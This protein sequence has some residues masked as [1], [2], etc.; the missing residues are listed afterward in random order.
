MLLH[1]R[2]TMPSDLTAEVR[3][4]I[5]GNDRT[6]NIVVQPGASVVPHGDLIECDVAREAGND[7]L[8][9]LAGLGLGERGGIIVTTP[10]DAPFDEARR[11]EELAPGDP[12]DVVIWA[13][14]QNEAEAMSRP[15][16]SYHIFLVLAVILAAIA[17]ITDSSILVVGAMVVGPEFGAIAAVCVGLVFSRRDLVVAGVKLVVF[18]FVF[19][20]AVVTLLGVLAHALGLI[21]NEAVTRPRPQTGFIWHPEPWSFVV[22]LVA[23]MAGVLA[24]S[25]EKA[26][27]MV[28]VLISVTTVPAAGNLA[29]GLAVWEP[30]EITGSLAQLGANISGLILAGT[31][32]LALQRRIWAPLTIHAERW[33]GQGAAR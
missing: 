10:T 7:L 21:T 13:S 11:L 16:V 19:A 12:D 4:L 1:L 20:I 28:G 30:D 25:T 24:L 27:A 3:A 2:L 14:V 15:T 9:N 29:I 6:T 33:F 26:S 31:L 17:V 32:F 22:A 23:G 8:D 18:G 5:E